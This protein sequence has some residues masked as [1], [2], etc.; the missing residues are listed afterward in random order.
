[1]GNL[2]GRLICNPS[3]SMQSGKPTTHSHLSTRHGQYHQVHS[4]PCLTHGTG[5]TASHCKERTSTSQHS[6]HHG[7]DTDTAQRPKDTSPQGMAT[8]GVS[9][10]SYRTSP[11]RPSASMTHNC[12]QTIWTIGSSKHANG[13]TYVDGTES[14]STQRNSY[15]VRTLLNSPASK[16]HQIV[17]NHAID[18]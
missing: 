9:T 13:L 16:S 10:K 14:P 17:Y 8:Q 1:M 18:S 11:T 7:E 15:S 2:G 6:S 4:K 12:G 3:T 5:T